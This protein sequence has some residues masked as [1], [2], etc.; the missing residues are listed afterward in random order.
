MR[1]FLLQVGAQV[2]VGYWGRGWARRVLLGLLGAHTFE[3][4]GAHELLTVNVLGGRG[5]GDGAR[6]GA[7]AD[8]FGL[9]GRLILDL[10]HEQLNALAANLVAWGCYRGERDRSAP[11]ERVAVA[12]GHAD[13]AGDGNA[14]VGQR[15]DNARGQYV[16]QADDKIGALVS[17]AFGNLGTDA[18][19]VGC[20]IPLPGIDDL[21]FDIRMQG[22]CL[23]DAKDAQAELH[24]CR[25]AH[26]GDMAC[27]AG[28]GE[29][30]D[31]TPLCLVVGGH[32]VTGLGAMDVQIDD[33][34]GHLGHSGV[35]VGGRHGL[36][37]DAGHLRA[38]KIAQVMILEN[39]VVIGIGDEQIV[40]VLAGLVV[41]AA[42]DLER[43][44][45][46]ETGE[47]QAK[48]LGGAA[49]ELTSALVGQVA[50]AID[51]LVDEP[52]GLGAQLLGMVERVGNRAKRNP[53]L[54]RDVADFNLC[55]SGPFDAFQVQARL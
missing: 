2:D 13:L 54:A 25:S 51:G 46:V 47:H 14:F 19:A 39:I 37:H 23:V 33:R 40:A 4:E 1:R 30:G 53:G 31:N 44:A 34:H 49:R 55:H 9:G 32:V 28:D 12:A 18:V 15:R 11:S 10:L 35:P 20:G 42:G 3:Q 26:N 36:N 48:G 38:H 43:K 27:A 24:K 7:D 41:G 8:S 17:R 52:E 5:R 50:Q 22:K 21:N 29:L 16:G 45:V 6:G